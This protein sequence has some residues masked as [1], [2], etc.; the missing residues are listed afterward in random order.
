VF[1]D[2][3]DAKYDKAVAC[4]TKDREALLALDHLQLETKSHRLR[5]SATLLGGAGRA[6]IALDREG[7]HASLE[8]ASP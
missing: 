3:Y 5:A 6:D 7:T 8:A 4:L 1:A 2:K